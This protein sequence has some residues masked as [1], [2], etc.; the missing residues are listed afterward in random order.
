M[1]ALIFLPLLLSVA[2]CACGKDIPEDSARTMFKDMGLKMLSDDRAPSA[3]VDEVCVAAGFTVKDLDRLMKQH[4]EARD[5]LIQGLRDGYTAELENQKK[6]LEEKLADATRELQKAKGAMTDEQA[7]RMRQM[8]GDTQAGLEKLDSEF[9]A[10]ERAV[11][12]RLSEAA[13][14]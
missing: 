14:N 5:W 8:K 10:R 13:R 4:P 1:R 12:D 2:V 3:V 7:A 9:S 6:A 11:Q